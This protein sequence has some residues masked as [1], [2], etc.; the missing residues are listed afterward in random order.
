MIEKFSIM[1]TIWIWTKV[2]GEH[3]MYLYHILRSR[4]F[5][6][7]LLIVNLLGT[8]YGYVWYGYQLVETEPRFLLFVPDSPTA[9]LFFSFVLLAFLFK[10]NWGMM[11]AFAIVTLLKYGTWAVGMNILLLLIE[12]TLDWTGYMLMISHAAMAIQGI[13]YA[14]FYRMK[15]WHLA[16]ASIWTLHDVVIDYVYK[17]MPRYGILD[18]Y[19]QPI[20]YFTFWLSICCIGAAYFFCLRE[21]RLELPLQ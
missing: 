16:A 7:L 13:L 9:S 20:G 11:E 4:S 3:V 8:A 14:P 15:R 10:V 1:I 12:G 18:Q 2:E 19:Y 5:L 17:Q 21:K 6:S